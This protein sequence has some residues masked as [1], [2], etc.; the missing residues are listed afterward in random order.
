MSW[1]GLLVVP[2]YERLH[3]LRSFALFRLGALLE[4]IFPRWMSTPLESYI[5]LR[6]VQASFIRT[7][8]SL[9]PSLGSTE[10]VH[11]LYPLAQGVGQQEHVWQIA[12]DFDGRSG[13][14]VKGMNILRLP[15]ISRVFHH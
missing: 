9:E 11:C 6:V 12:S 4:W 7:C 5:D 1:S 8:I 15:S 14:C 3:C 13:I 10:L 2:T